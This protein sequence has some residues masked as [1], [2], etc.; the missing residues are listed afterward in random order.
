MGLAQLRFCC[1]CSVC[2][3]DLCTFSRSLPRR[4]DQCP[5]R[6]G[7]YSSFFS[8]N[9]RMFIHPVHHH[10]TR[11][12]EVLLFLQCLCV[13]V[14]LFQVVVTS[15]PPVSTANRPSFRET[16]ALS[17]ILFTM[18][19]ANILSIVFALTCEP[20]GGRCA[21]FHRRMLCLDSCSSP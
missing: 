3:V 6:I 8:Q 20:T 16:L 14:H 15:Y 9:A 1:Y 21:E 5:R 10:G 17:S 12:A 7:A 2:C 19:L 13:P 18:G 4:I 11:A